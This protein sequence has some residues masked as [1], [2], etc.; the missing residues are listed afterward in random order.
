MI[1][2]MTSGLSDMIW[3]WFGTDGTQKTGSF[4]ADFDPDSYPE[5]SKAVDDRTANRNVA[6]VQQALTEKKK[7][8]NEKAAAVELKQSIDTLNTTTHEGSTMVAGSIQINTNNNVPLNIPEVSE[9]N[10][11]AFM[12]DML[13]GFP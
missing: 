11:M 5:V 13:G 7:A 10:S 2:D 12:G 1:S 6:V 4:G 9:E 8:D 3:N